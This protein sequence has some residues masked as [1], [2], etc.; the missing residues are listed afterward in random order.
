MGCI[1]AWTVRNL[2]REGA[3]VVAFDLAP[4]P[5]RIRQICT[6]EELARLTIVQGD[7]TDLA[8]V[9]QGLDEHGITNIIHLAALQVPFC[10]ADPPLGAR[11]NVLG[12]VNI[13]DAAQPP[14]G[15]DRA[16]RLHGLGRHVRRG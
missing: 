4:N 6:E 14:H 5:R 9:E 2:L 15:P 10:R 12:T 3:E 11:V 13:F 8:S 7:I 16:G 1:G